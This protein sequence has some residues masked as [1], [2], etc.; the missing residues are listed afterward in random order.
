MAII[1]QATKELQV[2]IVYYG[3]AMGGKTTNLVQ[4][5]DHVQTAAGNKGKLVSLAT[6]SDRTLFFDFL[7]I[8]AMT[9]KGFKTKFQ[10]YTVPGQVIY[11]TTRQLVLRGVD[12]IVFVAD[13]QYEKMPENVESF[14]NL[15]DNLKS[16]KL[17]LAEIP[18]VLQYNKR[19]LPNVAPVEYME[20]LLNNREVQVPSFTAHGPQ[21]R[22]R[23]RNAEHDHAPVAAQIHQPKRSAIRMTWPPCP[24]SSRK[25]SSSWTKT[26]REFIA[27]SRRHRRRWSLTRAA[28]SS[29][30]RA[31]PQ[32]FDLTTIAALASGAFMANQT[33][34]GLVNETNF[35]SIYQQGENFS[36][37]VI[38][39]DEHCLLVVIF[40]AQTG[41]GVVKYFRRP[42][43]QAHRGQLK[44]A[45]ERDPGE[46]LDLSVL[47]V[48]DRASI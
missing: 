1:N 46:G 3:P 27:Q 22:G 42:R 31:T 47:N 23:V 41:V 2:K 48:A 24:N 7:P 34:A 40:K 11:N 28:F 9:I 20:F 36:L 17:N 8:E 6:S 15:V 39:V 14:Q 4:V 33:I 21:V 35:N 43:R 37:F 12:G 16:L 25:T 26:L 38:N 30:T 18:Y 10:L 32:Q 13:S 29:R 45:R 19:D 44:I 5:H